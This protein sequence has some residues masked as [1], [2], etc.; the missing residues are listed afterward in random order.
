MELTT[1]LRALFWPAALVAASSCSLARTQVAPPAPAPVAKA[2]APQVESLDAVLEVVRAK[3]DLPALAATIL[4]GKDIVALGAVGFRDRELKTPVKSDDLWHLGSCTKAMTAT[5]AAKLVEQGK[6]TWKTTIGDAFP[7]LRE[8]LRKEWRDV[9]IELLLQN[10]GGVA[11][12][13]PRAAWSAL[14]SRTDTPRSARRWFV[15]QVLAEAPAAAPGTKFIYSNQGFT[16][17]G[18]MLEALT[19]TAWEEL[20]TKELFVPLGMT[21]AGFGA[22]GSTD[23][24]DQPRGHAPGPIAPGPRADNP[25]AIGPAGTVHCSLADWAKFVGA[26]MRGE[27]GEDGLLKA[28]SF[29]K[30]HECPEFQSYAMGWMRMP[31]KWSAG[32]AFTH[33]GSNTM[34]FCTVWFAPAI[35]QAFLVTT[36]C[37]SDKAGQA[38]DEVVGEL[39]KLRG[40]AK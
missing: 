37:A 4:S 24:V 39:L 1:A 21:S 36:N 16:I 35:D 20:I 10:R 29:R 22:P 31:R 26:H 13:P 6:L 40:L 38:C 11:G 30:L 28:T 32:D 12:D 25:P 8:T 27:K 15:E 17:A 23:L 14:W 19:D 2:E 5:L 33:S 7:E 18:A 9:S 34:W 3:Y